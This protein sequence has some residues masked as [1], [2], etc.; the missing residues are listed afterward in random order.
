[1]F[2]DLLESNYQ[3]SKIGNE[4]ML[5]YMDINI[6][7]WERMLQNQMELM[8]M[9]SQTGNRCFELAGQADAMSTYFEHQASLFQEFTQGLTDNSRQRT[10]I[11]VEAQEGLTR[12]VGKEV[13]AASHL[14]LVSSR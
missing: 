1:M 2:K 5:E 10:E 13:K 12:L 8:S 11:L 4:L 6:R 9:C 14:T 3:I 7:L